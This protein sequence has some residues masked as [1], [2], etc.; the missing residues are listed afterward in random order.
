MRFIAQPAA[1][2]DVTGVIDIRLP[3]LTYNPLAD[4]ETSAEESFMRVW[5]RQMNT[6]DIG[7]ITHDVW[8]NRIST[9]RHNTAF[10]GS[11]IFTF[12]G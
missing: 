6:V 2:D 5:R 8:L 7:G 9:T 1:Q 10:G 4:I 12:R 3:Y 11:T